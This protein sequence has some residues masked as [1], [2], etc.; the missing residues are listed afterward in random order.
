[1]T[2]PVRGTERLSIHGDRF[3]F[4]VSDEQSDIWMTELIGSH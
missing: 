2:H 3:Y 4:T 1:M